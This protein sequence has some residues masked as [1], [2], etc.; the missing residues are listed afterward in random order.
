MKK[1]CFN[2]VFS[3]FTSF[4]CCLPQVSLSLEGRPLPYRLEKKYLI[5]RI[6]INYSMLNSINIRAWRW[7]T[8]CKCEKLKTMKG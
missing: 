6:T 3:L 8:K 7:S 4:P 1:K 5:D 2:S